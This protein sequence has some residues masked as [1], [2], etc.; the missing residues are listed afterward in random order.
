MASLY[1]QTNINGLRLPNRFVRSATWDGLADDYGCVTPRMIDLTT[2]LADGGVGLIITG[3]AYVHQT[4]QHS[5]WQLG[6]DRDDV[7]PGLAKL[8]HSVHLRGGK[9]V[10]QL[11]FGGAY[12][13]KARLRSLTVEDIKRLVSWFGGAARRAQATG[14]DGVQIFAA[15]GF[16]LSQF[17]SPR[18]NPRT[19]EYGGTIENRGRILKE[20]FQSVRQMVGP[21]FPILVKLNTQ[22]FVE[23]GL[24]LQ[25][26]IFVAKMLEEQGLDALELSGGLLN[27]P[28]LL[29][30]TINSEEDEVYFLNEARAFKNDLTIPLIIVG[31]IR[32]YSVANQL[33]RD[34]VADY[35]SMCRPFICE[36]DLVN[37]WEAGDRST[38]A[39]KSCNNCIEEVKKG[40]GLGCVPLEPET[41]DT[42]FPQISATVAASPP[43]PTGSVYQISI[44]LEQHRATFTPV[45]KIQMVCNDNICDQSPFFPLESDDYANV[46]QAI[47][48]LVEQ[49]R[50]QFSAD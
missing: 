39:C 40:R 30:D 19:D 35:I 14:F 44:G 13:S 27:L 5:P 31:G 25:E 38:A 48:E 11:G 15:H 2:R 9:I 34:G 43:H 10:V 37:R 8:T 29:A 42:F 6:I 18:Y 3:H 22:D 47:N 45:I 28:N 24:T 17:L 23:N 41:Q 46:H 36:P 26:S 21:S 32:S 7:M 12:L 33:V 20:V 4:G 50:K 1:E 49:H 16:L